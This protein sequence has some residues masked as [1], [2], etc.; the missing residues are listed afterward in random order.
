MRYTL[1]VLSMSSSY[2]FITTY[3][4]DELRS[5]FRSLLPSQGYIYQYLEDELFTVPAAKFSSSATESSLIWIGSR[6]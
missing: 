6:A 5:V 2:Y 3:Q 4:I 1:K